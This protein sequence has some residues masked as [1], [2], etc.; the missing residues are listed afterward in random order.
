M[1]VTK[2]VVTMAW[3]LRL[4]CG[5]DSGFVTADVLSYP[6][7]PSAAP[8]RSMF[9]V[10]NVTLESLKSVKCAAIKVGPKGVRRDDE[11]KLTAVRRVEPPRRIAPKAWSILLACQPEDGLQPLHSCSPEN[12][13]GMMHPSSHSTLYAPNRSRKV[14]GVIVWPGSTRSGSIAAQPHPMAVEKKLSESTGWRSTAIINISFLTI[15][16]LIPIDIV[17]TGSVSALRVQAF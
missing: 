15:V 14:G 5:A 12:R 10:S 8:L 11:G 1:V 7:F 16:S 13:A 6:P 17:N 4:C 9:I 3:T 2:P